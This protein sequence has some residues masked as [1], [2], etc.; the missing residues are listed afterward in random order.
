M[1]DYVEHGREC[2]GRGAWREAYDAFVLADHAAPL[3]A[4]DLE[5]LATSAYLLGREGEFHK[6]L[7]RAHEAHTEANQRE[8]AARCAFWLA[9]T[10]LFRGETGQ[11]GGWL[12]R[13]GRLIEQRDCAEQGY[14][15]LPAAEQQLAQGAADAARATAARA[16]QIGGRFGDDDLV[17]CARHLEG[18]SLIQQGRM[19]EG[20]ALLDDAMLAVV[21]GELSPIVTGLM[22]CSV[23]DVCQRVYALRRAHEW[24]SALALWCE[25][26]PGMMAF[27]STCLVH[28]AEILQFH[29]AW[30]DAMAE[31]ARACDRFSEGIDLQP[32]AAAFYRRGEMHR[33]RGDFAAAEEA[34]RTAAHLGSEPQPGLALLRLA[35]GRNDAACAAIRRVLGA[36][37]ERTRRARLLPAY[38][39]IMLGAGAIEEARSACAELDEIASALDTDFLRAAAAQ[40]RGAAELASDHA[41]AALEPLRRA[42]ELWR[43]LQAPYEAACVR[44]LLGQA[45]RAL[46]DYEACELEFDAARAELKRLGAVPDL[47]RLQALAESA[48]APRGHALT[49]RELEVL[50]LVAAGKT[51]KSIARELRLSER[52]VDRH[53]SN[54]L[55]KLEVP[56]R[57][58]ATA[59]AYDRKLIQPSR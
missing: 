19:P 13:A 25:R 22:Y 1:P 11:A 39:E 55:T 51:N 47:A 16:A 52:T 46:G 18:R 20:L 49:A 5:R 50:R 2:F 40:A 23:I 38:I 8:R 54:I 26:Q 58:A 45:C 27:S 28:R 29:G 34:Y 14:L 30:S 44:L 12:A 59:C 57:A 53:V 31:A 37:G 21:R 35:Q 56:S 9:L 42:L 6:L 41:D 7:D 33:L 10:L 32:P 48:R 4:D 24:T 43:A 15:L 17:A 36:A 3:T